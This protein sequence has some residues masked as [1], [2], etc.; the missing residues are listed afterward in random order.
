MMS[1]MLMTSQMLMLMTLALLGG[2]VQQSR[3]IAFLGL[4]GLRAAGERVTARQVLED[5]VDI[6]IDEVRN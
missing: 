3:L 6:L 4:G 2:R 5:A 1:P